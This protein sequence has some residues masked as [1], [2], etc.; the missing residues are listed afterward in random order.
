MKRVPAANISSAVHFNTDDI[1]STLKLYSTPLISDRDT[2]ILKRV[3]WK[4]IP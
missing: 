1:N 3:S 4:G 2:F